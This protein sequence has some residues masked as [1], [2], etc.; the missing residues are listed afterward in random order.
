MPEPKP[1]DPDEDLLAAFSEEEQKGIRASA[2][3][4]VLAARVLDRDRKAREAEETAKRAEEEPKAAA[5]A[6]KKAGF[7]IF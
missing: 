1:K 7:K 6:K 4:R 5:E 3:A 2:A